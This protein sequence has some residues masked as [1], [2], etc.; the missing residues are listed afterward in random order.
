VGDKKVLVIEIK[1]GV[2]KPYCTA[3]ASILPKSGL[4]KEK[5]HKKN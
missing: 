2:N 5:Y 3:E 1:E 4:I